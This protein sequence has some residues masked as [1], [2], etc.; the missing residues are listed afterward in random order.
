MNDIVEGFSS[1]ATQWLADS[2]A[3]A[4]APVLALQALGLPQAM[5]EAT[6]GEQSAIAM[7]VG[8]AMGEALATGPLIEAVAAQVCG[9]ESDGQATLAALHSRAASAMS[10]PQGVPYADLA[11]SLLVN[12]GAPGAPRLARLDIRALHDLKLVPQVDGTTLGLVDLGANVP[13]EAALS[14]PRA[15]TA[16]TQVQDLLLLATSA[17]LIGVG[18][19]C[20]RI[21]SEH[22]ATRTQFGKTLSSFQ[23]LQHGVVDAHIDLTLARSLLER[24][25]EDWTIGTQ[26]RALLLALKSHASATAR[27]TCRMGVQWMGAMGFTDEGPAG[28]CLKHAL[29]LAARYGGEAHSRRTYR[30]DPIDLFA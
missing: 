12:V 5:A 16:A 11:Q 26:R 30:S 18:A 6:P 9:L 27:K 13:A 3:Y 20:L 15:L 2:A 29:V 24:V 14:G 8:L 10:T 25:V 4:A 17:R 21:A 19:R 22:L 23:V 28:P 1:A 7:A